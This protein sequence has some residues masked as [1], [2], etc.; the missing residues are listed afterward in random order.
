[1]TVNKVLF[2]VD[3]TSSADP[4]AAAFIEEVQKA[5]P[6]DEIQTVTYMIKPRLREG[7]LNF[8]PS[9]N[10][11]GRATYDNVYAA[12]KALGDELSLA[13]QQPEHVVL[14]VMPFSTDNS[15]KEDIGKIHETIN[16]QRY[17]YKWSIV[18]IGKNAIQSGYDLG[19]QDHLIL[20][21]L[22]V[23]DKTGA[24]IRFLSDLEDY[25]D[26]GFF[27]PEGDWKE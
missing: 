4:T 20:P 11:K 18:A 19:L 22:R 16:T 7:K 23:S 9:K 10:S 6:Q 17:I 8:S 27:Y 12:I 2:L 15:S 1:M 13:E 14:V 24:F 5:R 21:A 25:G 26:A 3:N